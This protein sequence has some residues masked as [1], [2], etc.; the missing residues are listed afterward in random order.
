MADAVVCKE[1][2]LVLVG[3]PVLTSHH[4]LSVVRV[5]PPFPVEVHAVAQEDA[6]A[7]NGATRQHHFHSHPAAR[8]RARCRP[9][10]TINALHERLPIGSYDDRTAEDYA[11]STA[12]MVVKPQQKCAAAD[13]SAPHDQ[14]VLT[15]Q[16]ETSSESD[17]EEEEEQGGYQLLPQSE[18]DEGGRDQECDKEVYTHLYA[19]ALGVT[20]TLQSRE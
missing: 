8:A 10:A 4:F 2:C 9:I 3:H 11:M 17:A 18:E 20:L 13:D 5:T 14:P 16:P 19:H 15:G 7:N 6:A 12:E 1:P